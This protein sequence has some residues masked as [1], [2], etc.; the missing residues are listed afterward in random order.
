MAH[1]E[2]LAWLQLFAMAVTFGPYFAVMATSPPSAPMPDL[3]TMGF[4]AVTVL[5]QAALLLIGRLVLR[6]RAP[7]EAGAPADERD[8]AISSRS[9]VAAYYVLISGSITVAVVMPFEESGWRLINAAVAM[10]VLAE[11]VH[12]GVAVHGYRRGVRV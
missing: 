1:R 6:L 4:F 2:K 7:D 11:L 8:R 5:T 9:V 12:Y 3:R 10:I